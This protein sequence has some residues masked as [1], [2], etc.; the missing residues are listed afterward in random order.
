QQS[1][2][3]EYYHTLLLSSDGQAHEESYPRSCAT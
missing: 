3:Q 2:L 1:P